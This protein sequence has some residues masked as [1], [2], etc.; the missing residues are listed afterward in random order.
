MKRSLLKMDPASRWHSAVPRQFFPLTPHCILR[1]P[2]A[3]VQVPAARKQD[4]NWAGP[5]LLGVLRLSDLGTEL[6]QK[7]TRLSDNSTH[8]ELPKGFSEGGCQ[9]QLLHAGQ[10]YAQ[11]LHAVPNRASRIRATD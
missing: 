3:L 7:G 6:K 10:S 5:G 9:E 4:T 2:G 8:F 1:P 11:V